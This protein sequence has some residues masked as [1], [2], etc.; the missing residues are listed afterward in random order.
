M[1][2][3][4]SARR[5]HDEKFDL[6]S[7]S[8]DFQLLPVQTEHRSE[9]VRNAQRFALGSGLGLTRTASD[10]TKRVAGQPRE[11]RR[12][13]A[14]RSTLH[15]TAA[16]QLLSALLQPGP[17]PLSALAAMPLDA[18]L[19]AGPGTPPGAPRPCAASAAAGAALPEPCGAATALSLAWLPGT[20]A[21]LHSL[22]SFRPTRQTAT[23]AVCLSFDAALPTKFI[24]S[25]FNELSLLFVYFF[26]QL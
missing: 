2:P 11:P 14:A 10:R 8:G 18:Q 3:P 16:P 9:T 17:A 12:D 19:P 5:L 1:S 25:F 13:T 22:P 26:D 21:P 4:R 23:R 6:N 15:T 7:D 24:C 20:A